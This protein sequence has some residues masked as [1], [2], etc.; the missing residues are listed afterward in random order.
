MCSAYLVPLEFC[1]AS[2]LFFTGSAEEEI[3]ESFYDG[4]WTP[5]WDRIWGNTEKALAV[6][7]AEQLPWPFDRINMTDYTQLLLKS[8]SPELRPQ[9]SH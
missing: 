2:F 1:H 7:V 9:T 8:S 3:R 4:A 5:D 6:A